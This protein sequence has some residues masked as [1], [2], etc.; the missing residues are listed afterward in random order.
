MSTYASPVPDLEPPMPG[1]GMEEEEESVFG[2]VGKIM[3]V[4]TP[5]PPQYCRCFA[6]QES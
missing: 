2:G 4:L 5:Q 1:E 3:Q 6:L